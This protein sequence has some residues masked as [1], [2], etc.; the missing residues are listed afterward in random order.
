MSISYVVYA[1]QALNTAVDGINFTNN[2]AKLQFTADLF[3][4]PPKVDAWGDLSTNAA[5]LLKSQL[6]IPLE[7]AAKPFLAAFAGLKAVN[8]VNLTTTGYINLIF[9]PSYWHEQ[10]PLL[11]KNAEKYGMDLGLERARRVNIRLPAQK[12]DL[13]GAREQANADVLERLAALAG[14]QVQKSEN[15]VRDLEG[16]SFEIAAAKCTASGV[17]FAL[18][19]N[20]PAFALS[21]SHNLAMDKTYNNPVFSIP[22]ALAT[23][24]KLIAGFDNEQPDAPDLTVLDAALE[25]KLAKLLCDWPLTVTKALEKEDVLY[26]TSFLQDVS[27]LFFRLRDQVRPVSSSYLHDERAAG[28]RVYLLKAVR[29]VLQRG[30]DVLGISVNKEFE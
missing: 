12:D 28:A 11:L 10:L 24:D 16:I 7:D 22:Y 15:Q 26:L 5:I 18:L 1:E 9:K 13:V 20:S 27:L 6:N 14:W 21:F 23:L 4:K 3:L 25:L 19:A 2:A 29:L 30:L 8:P 17:R